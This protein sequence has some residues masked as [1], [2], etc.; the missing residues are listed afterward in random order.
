MKNVDA[1]EKDKEHFDDADQR[2]R[3]HLAENELQIVEGRNDYLLDGAILLFLHYGERSNRK[4]YN[5]EYHHKDRRHH[6]IDTLKFR[7]EPC[8]GLGSNLRKIVDISD[9]VKLL[10]PFDDNIA[11]IVEGDDARITKSYPAGV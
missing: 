3:D 1:Y 10:R 5:H 2:E 6:E 7:V 4:S 9:E 11:R 8:T